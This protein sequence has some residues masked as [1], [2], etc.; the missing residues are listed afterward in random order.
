MRA[1]W[2]A[3]RAIAWGTIT[4]AVRHKDIYVLV[5]LT[6]M[7]V[8]G[9]GLMRFFGVRGMET[10]LKDMALTVVNIFAMIL[11][12][13]LAARQFPE[14]IK[15]RTLYPLLARP[16]TRLD[17][18]LGKFL[19]VWA[20]ATLA[21][22]LFAS[23]ASLILVWFD[24]TVGLLFVQ[25]VVLRAAS[26]GVICAMVL[27]LSFVLTPSANVTISLLLTVGASTF[28]RTAYLIHNS[29][30]GIAQRLIEI[31]YWIVPH[32]DLF[33]LSRKVAYGWAPIGWGVVAGIMVYGGI[34]IALFVAGGTLKFARQAL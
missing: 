22:L 16:I 17:F 23:V 33:D 27:F 11:A 28:S 7:L 19:G 18:V 10:F 12:V 14:E 32:F 9:A 30:S 21:L 29:T 8:G 1:R 13:L 15:R 26:L 31:A 25:Y 4:E 3:I 2:L 5:I 24:I 6:G 34:Y 20:M